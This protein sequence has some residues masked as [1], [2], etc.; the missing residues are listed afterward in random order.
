MARNRKKWRD[1]VKTVMNHLSVR[2]HRLMS[3]VVV[4]AAAAAASA[5]GS[6]GLGC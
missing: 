6:L 1:V 2:Q 5:A 4:V 3:V